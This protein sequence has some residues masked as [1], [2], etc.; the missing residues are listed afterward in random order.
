MQADFKRG[1]LIYTN[2]NPDLIIVAPH[3]GPSVEITTGR[4]DC[5]E[6]VASILWK[7]FGG[8]LIISNMPRKRL[9]GVDFNRDIPNVQL[10]LKS[11]ELFDKNIE[12]E[13][14]YDYES[15]YAWVAKNESDYD[16][17]LSI[18][19]NFWAEV[20]KGKTILLLHR[21]FTRLKA[22][23]SI[24]DIVTFSNE[25]IEKS[26]ISDIVKKVNTKYYNFLKRVEQGYKQTIYMESERMVAHVIQLYKTFDLNK[27]KK[28]KKESFTLDLKNI[29][30][31]SKDY[32]YKRLIDNFTPQNYLAAVKSTLEKSPTPQLTVENVFDGSL[33]LGPKRKL[34]PTE[35]KTIIEIEP[36][37]FLNLWYPEVTANIIR[38]VMKSL[39]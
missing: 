10:A 36:S 12:D 37:Y 2:E 4:D 16:N 6:T 18:Y 5:S 1:F 8:N 25:G 13:M 24:M 17:R 14:Q 29:K 15:K 26:I 33:A 32:I 28:E 35:G 38:D 20:A 19:Q 7:K 30:K 34:F 23:P 31:Y 39:K 11:Y 27:V 9:W 3:S 22:L 21:A